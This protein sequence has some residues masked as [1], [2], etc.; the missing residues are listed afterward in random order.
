MTLAMPFT[1]FSR[2]RFDV[3]KKGRALDQGGMARL[4]LKYKQEPDQ[5]EKHIR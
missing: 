4:F 1:C 5:W 3:Y 2:Q